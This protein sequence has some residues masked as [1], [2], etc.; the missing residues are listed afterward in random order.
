ML[1]RKRIAIANFFGGQGLD[2]RPSMRPKVRRFTRKVY[3][4]IKPSA[5]YPIMPSCQAPHFRRTSPGKAGSIRK[6]LHMAD[7]AEVLIR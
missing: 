4:D 7:S 2:F 6:S 1:G 5:C 3:P